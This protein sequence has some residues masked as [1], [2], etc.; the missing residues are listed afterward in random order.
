MSNIFCN[1]IRHKKRFIKCMK[2]I[3]NVIYLWVK[4]HIFVVINKIRKIIVIVKIILKIHEGMIE[5]I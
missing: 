1:N 2:K 3:L 4:I 5:V